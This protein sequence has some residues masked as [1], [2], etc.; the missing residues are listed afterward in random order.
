MRHLLTA[1]LGLSG[2]FLSCGS[3][4]G[5]EGPPPPPTSTRFAYVSNANSDELTAYKVN[6]STGALTPTSA[7]D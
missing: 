6:S 2:I 3:A 4:T 7:L 5:V 1:C